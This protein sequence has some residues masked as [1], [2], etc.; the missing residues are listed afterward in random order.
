MAGKQVLAGQE[1]FLAAD[2]HTNKGMHPYI[3]PTI[4]LRYR[5]ANVDNNAVIWIRGL[6]PS[7]LQCWWLIEEEPGIFD[8]FGTERTMNSW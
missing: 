6:D 8:G 2:P 5:G 1:Q 7:L 4:S 3:N